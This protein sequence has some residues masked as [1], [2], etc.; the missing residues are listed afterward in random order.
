[1]RKKTQGRDRVCEHLL[2]D[3]PTLRHNVPPLL[4]AAYILLTLSVLYHHDRLRLFPV[5]F[6]H[7]IVKP[8]PPMYS[9]NGYFLPS[10]LPSFLAAWLA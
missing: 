4:G 8:P 1:M 3:G 7:P 10:F 9:L 6:C 2:L 5:I